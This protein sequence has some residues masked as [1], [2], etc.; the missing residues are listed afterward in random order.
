[1]S[2]GLRLKLLKEAS[3]LPMKPGVYLMYGESD[4]VVYVGKSK[5]LRDRVSQYFNGGEKTVKTSKMV[6]SVRR[7][8]CIVCDTE[9]EALALENNLIKKY[10]P[11]Y[12]IRLKD[13]KSYP[14]IRLS[15]GDFPRLSMTR[16][17]KKD[18]AG[19]FGP[20][21]GTS[22]VFSIIS[23][24]NRIFALPSCKY[25]F[26]RD[27]GKVRPCI[28]YQ[29]G[30]CV[31]VCTG[32]ID[33]SAYSERIASVEAVLRGKTATVRAE[34]ERKMA[35]YAEKEQYEE[36]A[37]CR[38]TLAAL[39]KLSEG[40][41][42]VTDPDVFID[43][44]AIYLSE[45][46]ST[47]SVIRIREGRMIGKM[48]F[49]IGGSGD[50]KEE[51]VNLICEFY[52][53]A[54]EV[55]P[56]IL[57]GSGYSEGDAEIL[58][59]YLC[60]FSCSRV[61]VSVPKI[62]RNRELCRMAEENAKQFTEKT[63]RNRSEGEAVLIK[64]AGALNLEVV[65]GRIEAYDVSNWGNEQITA[66]MI[67]IKNGVPS[68]RDYRLF[69][70]KSITEQND[71]ASMKEAL[72]RRLVR[73]NEAMPANDR[74]SSDS[75]C[76]LPDLILVDGG[77]TQLEAAE[78]AVSGA[79][80][81]IPVAG[82]VK[83]DNHRTRTLLTSGGEI[84]IS[85]DRDLFSFIYRIQEEIHRFTVKSMAGAK[86]R[87]IKKSS[88]EKIHGIGKKKAALLL[89][90]FGGISAVRNADETELS[91]VRGISRADAVRIREYFHPEEKE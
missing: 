48:D 44:F 11:R 50:I 2:D 5:K 20:Y 58:E 49:P 8:E 12:N 79:G 91:L 23:L 32:R 52:R 7:F 55:P 56:G 46:A 36:A 30:R 86:R 35:D 63:V 77:K 66:G 43:V 62:G 75:F 80:L 87:T 70:M 71:P 31:G 65:P 33:K 90:A 26:P 67:V 40:Q 9:I 82:M 39:R 38:D 85:R 74:E 28:Y 10:S 13:A 59:R 84:D 64:L 24:I 1:M 60:G 19:Y 6:S 16:D 4:R 73:L 61:R 81:E 54:S 51:S 14:Y 25:E 21:S 45:A 34:L 88:L 78:R 68:K 53:D 69:R 72:D 29:M 42:A 76:E 27:T 18:G 47:L 57:L 17:R 83:D 15:A 3:E 22:S 37:V 41:K 89:S